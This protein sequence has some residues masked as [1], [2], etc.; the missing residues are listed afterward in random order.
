MN[1]I[2]TKFP[3]LIEIWYDFPRFMNPKQSYDFYKLAY[4]Q[5]PKCHVNSR[6]GNEFGD[7]K[8]AGDNQIST[9]VNP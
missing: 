8:V 1:E 2:L 5:Q 7:Y 3:D 4:D 6:V 9:S